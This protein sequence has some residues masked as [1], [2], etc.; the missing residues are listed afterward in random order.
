MFLLF[1]QRA[2]EY[3]LILFNMNVATSKIIKQ[4]ELV[5]IKVLIWHV[6]VLNI[7]TFTLWERQIFVTQT[8]FGIFNSTTLTEAITELSF[9]LNKEVKAR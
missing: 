8:T 1:F 5:L 2:A 6:M 4:P 9:L 7:P 3:I